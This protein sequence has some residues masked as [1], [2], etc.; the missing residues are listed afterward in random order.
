MLRFSKH[1]LFPVLKP[2]KSVSF[3]NQNAQIRIYLLDW[4]SIDKIKED[5]WLDSLVCFPPSKPFPGTLPVGLKDRID[6]QSYAIPDDFLNE[7]RLNSL[8]AAEE[9]SRQVPVFRPNTLTGA[10]TNPA[11]SFILNAF[12]IL[13][14][15]AYDPTTNYFSRANIKY[16]LPSILAYRFWAFQVNSNLLEKNS[17]LKE[18]FSGLKTLEKSDTTTYDELSGY[19]QLL[20]EHIE[21]LNKERVPEKEKIIEEAS[22]EDFITNRRA[23]A[24]LDE[25]SIN[26]PLIGEINL[27]QVKFSRSKHI[28]LYGE[29]GSQYVEK[30]LKVYRQGDFPTSFAIYIKTDNIIWKLYQCQ[31]ETLSGNPPPTIKIKVGHIEKSPSEELNGTVYPI[32]PLLKN[33]NSEE[34]KKQTDEELKNTEDFKGIHIKTSK[35]NSTLHRTIIN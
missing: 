15:C 6:N 1:L 13:A 27:L 33:I 10:P 5:R 28:Y 4:A 2:L 26:L 14:D 29:V 34:I 11:I 23:S 25:L 31:L 3:K 19:Y 32:I 17:G 18:F 16:I 8:K 20:L 22:F 7:I 35:N 12:N 21:K 24:T 30:V 9:W